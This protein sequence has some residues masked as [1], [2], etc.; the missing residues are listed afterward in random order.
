MRLI[1]NV[2]KPFAESVLIP[3]GLTTAVS[4]IYTAIYE[5]MFESGTTKLKSLKVTFLSHLKKLVYWQKMF[6]KQLKM[7]QNN[8]KKDFLV[9]Y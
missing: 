3:W 6:A 1:G 9:C 2:L 7:K 8:K 5:K 4:A